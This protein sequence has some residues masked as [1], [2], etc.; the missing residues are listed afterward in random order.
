MSRAFCGLALLLMS[1]LPVPA[2]ELAQQHHGT[3]NPAAESWNVG[4]S[5]SVATQGINDGGTPAWRMEDTGG[6]YL[7]YTM[8]GLDPDAYEKAWRN[9]TRITARL[10]LPVA[11]DAV[12]EGC[13]LFTSV[14]LS[15]SEFLGFTVYFGTDAA[16]NLLVYPYGE[17]TVY[18]ATPGYHDVVLQHIGGGTSMAVWVDGIKIATN[19]PPATTGPGSICSFGTLDDATGV[20]HWN[21]VRFE[22]DDRPVVTNVTAVAGGYQVAWLAGTNYVSSLQVSSSPTT[23]TTWNTLAGCSGLAWRSFLCC[24]NPELSTQHF[25]RVLQYQ[26]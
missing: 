12:D 24:T 11:G 10:R 14:R 23:A 15:D 19:V 8:P 4:T 13:F 22:V 7:R 1:S 9:G 17:E 18:T 5:G 20:T 16:T 2:W 25:F 26:P 21:S 3:N 6:G